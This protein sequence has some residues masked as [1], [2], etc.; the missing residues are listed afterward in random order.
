MD[1]ETFLNFLDCTL[2]FHGLAKDIILDLEQW[3]YEIEQ[4]ADGDL[5]YTTIPWLIEDSLGERCKQIPE[6]YKSPPPEQDVQFVFVSVSDPSVQSGPEESLPSIDNGRPVV[7]PS[8]SQRTIKLSR[9]IVGTAAN[10]FSRGPSLR[11]AFDFVENPHHGDGGAG[12]LCSS[13]GSADAR[14]W[15]DSVATGDTSTW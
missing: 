2:R 7:E 3:R 14:E 11:A 15:E 10:S 4:S 6:L 8:W 13:A 5:C 9:S 1:K 12:E